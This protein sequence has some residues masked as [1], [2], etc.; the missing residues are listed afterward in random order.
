MLFVLV[1]AMIIF[2]D[3]DDSGAPSN[4]WINNILDSWWQKDYWILFA[5]EHSS[6]INWKDHSKNSKKL[7]STGGWIDYSGFSQILLQESRQEF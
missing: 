3:M 1:Q 6:Y 4:Q 7:Y 2:I 5:S